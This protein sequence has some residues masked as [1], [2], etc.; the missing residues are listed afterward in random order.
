MFFTV[1]KILT[2][3]TRLVKSHNC[4]PFMALYDL[5]SLLRSINRRLGNEFEMRVA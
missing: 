4:S 3:N 1:Q 2:E 5:K